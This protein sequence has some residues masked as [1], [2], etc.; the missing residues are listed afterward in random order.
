MT[1]VSLAWQVQIRGSVVY[2]NYCVGVEVRPRVPISVITEGTHLFI[3][4]A[5]S[6][7]LVLRGSQSYDPDHP[8]AVLR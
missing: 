5:A 4:R 6:A 3:P 8:E 7:P 2:S 1:P